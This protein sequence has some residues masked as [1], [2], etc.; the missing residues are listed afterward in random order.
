MVYPSSSCMT[1]VTSDCPSPHGYEP[2]CRSFDADT[3]DTERSFSLGCGSLDQV[4]IP[5]VVFPLMLCGHV[6]PAT[7]TSHAVVHDE[8]L[9]D[10]EEWSLFTHPPSANNNLHQPKHQ[11]C[12]KPHT[13]TARSLSCNQD[14]VLRLASSKQDCHIL[15]SFDA[16]IEQKSSRSYTHVGTVQSMLS[17]SRRNRSR[18]SLSKAILQGEDS[19]YLAEQPVS[20]G[21]LPR[22][23][24]ATRAAN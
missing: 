20:V 11:H 22:V 18:L 1:I 12:V 10:D 4:C 14:K 9:T 6:V 3:V 21:D 7:A 16:Q 15:S 2:V 19:S 13:T 5:L 24:Q 23:D 8:P 17:P